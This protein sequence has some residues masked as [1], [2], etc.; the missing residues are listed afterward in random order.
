MNGAWLARVRWRRRGAWLWPTFALLTLV[1]A[2]VGHALPPAGDTQT[3][4]AAALLGCALNLIGVVLLSWPVGALIRRARGDLPVVVARNYAGTLIVITVALVLFVAG[5]AHRST[6]LAHNDAL[7]E[8]EVRAEAWIGDRA[9][10]EFR[11][12]AAF[13]NTFT[14]EPGNIYRSCVASST[15]AGRNYCV[16]VKPR[17]PLGN[18]VRYAGAEPNLMFGDGAG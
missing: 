18:S 5:L 17:L 6:V 2:V 1:D 13:I 4:V 8:A 7:R 9:P 16:I 14:I 10:P 11:R 12:N 3:V 15:N